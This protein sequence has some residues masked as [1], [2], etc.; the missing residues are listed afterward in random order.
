MNVYDTTV[1]VIVQDIRAMNF[2]NTENLLIEKIDPNDFDAFVKSS[3]ICRI[4]CH[5][6]KSWGLCSTVQQMRKGADEVNGDLVWK[7]IKHLYDSDK[8]DTSVHSYSNDKKIDLNVSN[9]RAEA[10]SSNFSKL[11]N[12][13]DNKLTSEKLFSNENENNGNNF[14]F[15][16]MDGKSLSIPVETKIL[17]RAYNSIS[18]PVLTQIEQ[19]LVNQENKKSMSNTQSVALKSNNK[20]IGIQK[21]IDNY[22]ANNQAEKKNKYT[23]KNHSSNIPTSLWISEGGKKAHPKSCSMFII[24]NTIDIPLICSEDNLNFMIKNKIKTSL[25]HMLNNNVD[26]VVM[27]SLGYE[28]ECAKRGIDYS[29][30]KLLAIY[31]IVLEEIRTVQSNKNNIFFSEICMWI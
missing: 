2:C 6:P 25:F 21:K 11:Y 9:T 8:D 31:K 16:A 24:F 28:Q 14:P 10:R 17:A 13:F 7:L 27:T 5:H 1:D 22:V 3:E 20:Y 23:P 29:Y 4:L 12:T 19:L 15:L 26:K 18:I 30:I